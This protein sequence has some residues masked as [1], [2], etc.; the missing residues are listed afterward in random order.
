MAF[1]HDEYGHFEGHR[2]ARQPADRAR[3][4]VPVLRPISTPIRLWSSATTAAGGCRARSRPTRWP[5]RSCISLPE[6]RDYATAA[7][8]ALSVLKHIPEVGERFTYR[9]WRFE[10]VDMDGRKIDKLLAARSSGGGGLSRH[11]DSGSSPRRVRVRLSPDDVALAELAELLLEALD[12]AAGEIVGLLDDPVAGEAALERAHPLVEMGD[13]VGVEAGELVE[14]GDAELV[15]AARRTWGRRPSAAERSS[16]GPAGSGAGRRR[17]APRRRRRWSAAATSSA[18]PLP[19][20]PSRPAASYRAGP[21]SRHRGSRPRPGARPSARRGAAQ[22]EEGEDQDGERSATT[23]RMVLVSN[24]MTGR[25]PRLAVGP[26]RRR[27]E[28]P[29]AGGDADQQRDRQGDEV[30]LDQGRA[31]SRPHR[32]PLALAAAEEQP[33]EADPDQIG[34]SGEDQGLGEQRHAARPRSSQRTPETPGIGADAVVEPG[35]AAHALALE[36]VGRAREDRLARQ[37]VAG[38]CAPSTPGSA[39]VA[40]PPPSAWPRAGRRRPRP[41]RAARGRSSRRRARRRARSAI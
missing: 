8:F 4:Q 11:C 1:V 3:R 15:E 13:L 26:A 21:G 22:D 39:A 37:A 20:G 34:Q 17:R 31:S 24:V 28:H 9:G 41:G 27:A 2:D 40:R 30:E 33:A 29:A 10:I 12:V 23:M 14:A 32:K 6:D 19:S 36:I 38:R 16:A 7:G 35:Q 5:T 25:H 18:T